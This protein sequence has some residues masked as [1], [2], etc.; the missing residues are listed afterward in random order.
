MKNIAAFIITCLP[1]SGMNQEH[2]MPHYFYCLN[3]NDKFI[4]IFEMKN[5]KKS[6]SFP[7]AWQVIIPDSWIVLKLFREV[8]S[9]CE[10]EI[11]NSTF[12]FR[13]KIR[14][15]LLSRVDYVRAIAFYIGKPFW[16]GELRVLIL[17]SKVKLTKIIVKITIAS[18][19]SIVGLLM[20]I[21]G[22]IINVDF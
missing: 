1:R 10:T 14:S 19:C 16:F 22:G 3:K 13:R 12:S 21:N 2:R 5:Y 20:E 11:S 15:L 4:K 9:F 18:S 8:S 17:V 6:T 7:N